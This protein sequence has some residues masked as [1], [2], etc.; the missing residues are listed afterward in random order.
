MSRLSNRDVLR[1]RLREIE[2]LRAAAAVLDWDQQ[3]YMPAG[4]GA[5]RA[6]HIATLRRL[7]HERLIDPTT[8]HLL[9]ALQAREHELDDRDR[10]MVRVV[11]RD[12]ERAARVPLEFM[13]RFNEHASSTY[14][15]WAAA[16]ASGEFRRV[17]PLLERTLEYSREYSALFPEAEHPA[18][19]HIDLADEGMTVATLTPLFADLRAALV[20][21]VEAVGGQPPPPSVLAG[22]FPRETQLRLGLEL[23]AELGF[24]ASCGRLDVTPHPFATRLAHGDV[25]VTTRCEVDDLTEA[26]FGTLHEAGHGMYEQGIDPS[27]E[28][29]LLAQGVSAGVHESQ[30]RLWENL[31]GRSRDYW[32]HVLPRLQRAFPDLARV[33]VDAAYREVNRVTPSLVRTE[34]DE[35]TYNLHVLIRFDLELALLEGAIGVR[36]LP[37]AWNA[38]YRSDLG[39][40]PRNDREGVL[41]DVHWYAGMIGGEFQGYA[42]GNV[43]SA[44]FFAAARDAVGDLDAQIREGTFAPLLSWLQE[45]VHRYG[46][47][48]SPETLVEQATGVPMRLEP[49]LSYLEAKYAALYQV[50]VRAA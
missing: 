2:D 35:L 23:A 39:I 30:S 41:Q 18:D 25:R 31:V 49:Y 15:A 37:D 46:R 20:P 27:L 1:R 19:P 38:R 8:R 7:A 21:M 36:E 44:Q 14:Q 45:H 29:T 11:S 48:R 10:D 43:L 26:L 17:A 32:A 28:G 40:E 42:I 3:T 24:D 5:A 6:R 9:D 12:V 47:R 22:R 13:E 33:D 4:G 50:E 16:R 34:A